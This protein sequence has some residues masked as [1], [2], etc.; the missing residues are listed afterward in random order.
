M[1]KRVQAYGAP[2]GGAG[3]GLTGRP[4]PFSLFIAEHLSLG[5]IQ[6]RCA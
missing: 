6:L 3:F 2:R 5:L 4:V 1:M